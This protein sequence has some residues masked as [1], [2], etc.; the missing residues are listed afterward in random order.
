MINCIILV[1][2]AIYSFYPVSVEGIGFGVGGIET[3][4][5]ILFFFK[6]IILSIMKVPLAVK[7]VKLWGIGLLVFFAW[8]GFIQILEEPF[9]YPNDTALLSIFIVLNTYTYW[10]RKITVEQINN[11]NIE[12]KTTFDSQI[13]DEDLSDLEDLDL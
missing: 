8:L 12:N 3:L 10:Y 13:L 7:K 4:M 2:F 6:D 1:S 9:T 11:E 5:Y